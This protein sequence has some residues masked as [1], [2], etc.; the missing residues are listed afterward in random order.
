MNIENLKR[1]SVKN[2]IN[3]NEDPSLREK[4]FLDSKIIVWL[5]VFI[6]LIAVISY[7]Y[8]Q[9]IDI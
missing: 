5:L 7:L 2:P 1:A 4:T 9:I 8:L 6:L 3:I